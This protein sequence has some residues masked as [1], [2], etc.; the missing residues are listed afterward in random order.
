MDEKLQKPFDPDTSGPL[1]GPER[2][3]LYSGYVLVAIF[4][5]IAALQVLDW[6]VSR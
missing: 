6:A 1:K 3:V 4:V 5:F 2:L